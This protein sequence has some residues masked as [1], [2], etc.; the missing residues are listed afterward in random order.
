MGSGYYDQL[1]KI[2]K[3]T[4]ATYTGKVKAVTKFGLVQSSIVHSLLHLLLTIDTQ[5]TVS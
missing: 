4:A 2:L 3:K 5:P 1:V